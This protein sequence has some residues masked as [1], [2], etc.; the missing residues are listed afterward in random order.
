MK[1]KPDIIHCH[2]AISLIPCFLLNIN[3]K[4]KIIYDAHELES[5]KNGQSKLFKFIT[6]FFESIMWKKINLL[7]SVSP[8]IINWYKDKYGFKK[9]LLLLNKPRHIKK[10]QKENNLKKYLI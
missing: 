10:S 1:I 6:L 9:S 4:T 7:I 3:R 2:D 8:S 5:D